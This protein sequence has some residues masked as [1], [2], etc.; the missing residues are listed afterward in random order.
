MLKLPA[1]DGPAPKLE[2][3]R[4]FPPPTN[5]PP[6]VR[7]SG[8]CVSY[9]L[10]T[11]LGMALGVHHAAVSSAGTHYGGAWGLAD[12]PDGPD[13]S[14]LALRRGNVAAAHGVPDPRCRADLQPYRPPALHFRGSYAVVRSSRWRDR[15][16]GLVSG[17]VTRTAFLMPSCMHADNQSKG[18]CSV[19]PRSDIALL[20]VC[21]LTRTHTPMCIVPPSHSSL[22]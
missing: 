6:P 21:I 3:C 9:F 15:T 18:R 8:P 4:N 14:P 20:T 22:K 7:D 17:L 19:G 12:S 5:S 10:R 2:G 1:F 11:A 16:G 13:T